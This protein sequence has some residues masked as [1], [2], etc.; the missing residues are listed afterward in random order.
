AGDAYD[1]MAAF[2]KSKTLVQLKE[3]EE[4]ETI[5]MCKALQD[6]AARERREGRQEGRSEGILVGRNEGILAGRTEGML[7]E[8]LAN[9]RA[10]MINL[11]LTADKAMDVLNVPQEERAQ[12]AAKLKII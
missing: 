5:D 10:I 12:Y 1:V 2:V 4:G 6:W 11:K 9:L 7:E 8:K 3:T